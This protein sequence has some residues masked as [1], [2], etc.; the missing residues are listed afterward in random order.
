MKK[1]VIFASGSGTNA[2][3][4]T[5][6]FSTA[7]TAKVVSTF[8]NNPEASVIKRVTDLGVDVF[9]FDRDD[10]YV[11]GKVAARLSELDPDIVVLAG[12][13]WHIPDAITSFYKGRLVN[14]H[15]EILPEFGGK[16]M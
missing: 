12:F 6:Y 9:L 7:K 11:N 4:I 16:G 15:P 8:V 13:L 3:N 10:L 5:G 2:A 1:I 14:I